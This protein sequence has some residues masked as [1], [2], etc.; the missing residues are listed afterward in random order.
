[1]K[2]QQRFD[3]VEFKVIEVGG[4]NGSRH[5]FPIKILFENKQYNYIFSSIHVKDKS[6]TEELIM[7]YDHEDEEEKKVR[8]GA[9]QYCCLKV[10]REMPELLI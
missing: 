8:L 6:K 5:E 3:V 7:D 10:E 4:S 1:M 2:E 9:F